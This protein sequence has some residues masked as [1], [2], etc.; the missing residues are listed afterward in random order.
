MDGQEEQVELSG[1]GGMGLKFKGQSQMLLTVLLMC[2]LAGGLWY[3]IN[4][5]AAES[6]SGMSENTAALKAL[7]AEVKSQG[8]T[9]KAV[10]YVLTLPEKERAKLDLQKPEKLKEMQR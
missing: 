1:P 2:A 9:M 4:G 6:K 3:V 5:H 8:D 10:I 7:T